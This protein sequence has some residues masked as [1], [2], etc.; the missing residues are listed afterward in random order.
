MVAN[1]VANSVVSFPSLRNP[2]PLPWAEADRGN[3]LRPLT[4]PAGTLSP[5][6]TRGEGRVR[7][8]RTLISRFVPVNR[9]AAFRRPPAARAR[10]A[11]ILERSLQAAARSDPANARRTFQAAQRGESPS[12]VNAAFHRWFM[13]RGARLG[14]WPVS[15]SERNKALPMNR[16]IVAQVSNL[17][18]CRFPV[19]RPYENRTAGG[20]EIRDTADWKS[21]LQASAGSWVPARSSFPG[22]SPPISR[23]ECRFTVPLPTA[24]GSISL[25]LNIPAPARWPAPRPL[26]RP[27]T[28]A[29]GCWVP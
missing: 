29:R 3:D 13:G 19:G 25:L 9:N 5:R 26:P 21:A 10:V 17:L 7:I 1:L 18:Y 15:R 28:Y 14:S 11:E 8:L 4:R 12:S 16:R 24:L 2:G 23:G 6:P 20:L 22:N 27:Q